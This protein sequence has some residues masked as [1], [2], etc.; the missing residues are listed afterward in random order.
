MFDSEFIDSHKEQLTKLKRI[1]EKRKKTANARVVIDK[2]SKSIAEA[3]K[4]E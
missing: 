3:H 1:C 2:G 4:N